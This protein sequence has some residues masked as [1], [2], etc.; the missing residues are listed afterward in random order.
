MRR[1]EP[2]KRRVRVRHEAW[3]LARPFA[4]SRGVKTQADVVVVE[5]TD[6][7]LAGRGECVPYPRYGE[8][9]AGVIEDIEKVEAALAAGI[10]R[11]QLRN[12]LAAGA[13]RNAVDAALWDLEAK[14]QGRR[15]WQIA[16]L[17]QP[18]PCLTAETIG[19]GTIDEM[20]ASARRLAGAPLIK[21]KLDDRQVIERMQAV[22]DQAPTARLIIDPNEGWSL[23][24]L[25]DVAPLLCELGVEMIEQPLSATDDAG[26]AAY[27]CPLVLCADEACHTKEGL[28][29]LQG[30]YQMINIKLDK[31]GGLTEALELAAAAR[32]LD[33]QIMVG[34]MVGT[35]LAM[36]PA[37]L[38]G[39][40]ARF[41]DLDGPLLLKQDRQP[42]LRF[43]GGYVHPPAPELWG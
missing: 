18:G 9:V 11:D 27:D 24:L 3:P 38:L 16:G 10:E 25:R 40:F 23:A 28:D 34:C 20:A 5:I 39:C 12:V 30:K 37:A 36:A 4:I 2:E 7:R 31:T 17:D 41:V 35:S 15:A 14:T 29:Q 22:R 33:F 21:V 19:I 32:E 8:T 43:D 6:G 1:P 13:A 42:G 26:L